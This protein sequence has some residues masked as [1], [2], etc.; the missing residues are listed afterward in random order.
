MVACGVDKHTTIIPGAW[1]DPVGLSNGA[2]SLQF[3]VADE[4]GVLRQQS[5]TGHVCGPYNI[6]AFGNSGC[7]QDSANGKPRSLIYEI[8]D[9]VDDC[10]TWCIH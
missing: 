5:H 4:D 3:A 6:P 8:K 9:C 1:L 7:S 10:G 2:K